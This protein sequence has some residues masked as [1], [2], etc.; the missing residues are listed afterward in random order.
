MNAGPDQEPPPQNPEPGPAPEPGQAEDQEQ[1]DTHALGREFSQRAAQPG[2]TGERLSAE[3]DARSNFTGADV[4]AGKVVGGDEINYI[5]V[6]A[7]RI[8][9]RLVELSAED[10]ELDG[11]YVPPSGVEAIEMA[12]R[13][14]GVLLLRGPAE[15]GRYAL[16]RHLLL[17]HCGG[18]VRRLHPE[19][20]LSA[21]TA[22]D[23]EPGGYLLSDLA[24]MSAGK[25]HS[26]DLDRLAAELAGRH[27]LVI[28]VADDVTFADPDMDRHVVDA[29]PCDLIAVLRAHLTRALKSRERADAMLRDSALKALCQDHLRA[30]NPAAAVRLAVLLAQAKE[31]I[32]ESV[33]A[34]LSAGQN[35]DPEAWFGGLADLE[36]QTLA[37]GVA[38]LGGEP[39]EVVSSAAEALKKRLEPDDQPAKAA[40]PFGATRG[41]RLR[42]LHAHL[43]RSDLPT[44]HGATAPGLVV[45][46]QDRTLAQRVLLHVWD[47]YDDVRSELLT[48]LRLCA[49]S[50]VPT[51]RVRAAVATGLLATRAF[52]HIRSTIILPWAR[53][54]EPDLRDAAA[55]ALGV[56][57]DRAELRNAV[58]GLVRAWGVDASAPRLQATAARAWRIRLTS[59]GCRA[60]VDFLDTLGGETEPVVVEAVCESIAEMLEY[61]D[62]RF[63]ADALDLLLMWAKSRNPDKRVTARLAFLLAAA[64]LVRTTRRGE[65]WPTLLDLTGR[66]RTQATA[67][68]ELWS[69]TLNSADFHRAAKEVLAEWARTVDGSPEAA[70]ALGRL[71]AAAAIT[72][73]TQRIIC[74]AAAGWSHAPKTQAVVR[75][76]L[77]CERSPR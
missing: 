23:L 72:P 59:E 22:A 45:R 20:D 73:R 10:L 3:R 55:S 41:A 61:E 8:Q 28:T 18:L 64:D 2:G 66:N 38:V 7:T 35:L 6:T 63:A 52:D 31:P 71:V 47:E 16:A 60:A 74:I 25:L 34:L 17:Q 70:A 36:S 12:V 77:P 30:A 68:A 69:A 40:H 4:V 46:Y 21:L 44:R 39:Y 24:P 51:V 57:A 56:A 65:I 19:T 58:L 53:A 29:P 48:W 5:T 54:A 11:I 62:S 33:Q 37:L 1:R 75:T 42:A 76:S 43:V 13:S 15:S 27:V 67:I 32:A 50:E 49:R 26:F 9:L 14:R